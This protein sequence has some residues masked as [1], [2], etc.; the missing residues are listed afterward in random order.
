MSSHITDDAHQ[1]GHPNLMYMGMRRFLVILT[2]ALQMTMFGMLACAR[3]V[4]HE[5]EAQLD[6]NYID[7]EELEDKTELYS[8]LTKQDV[9]FAV[10]V[11]GVKVNRHLYRLPP[12][13]RVREGSPFQAPDT[14][15]LLGDVRRFSERQI[16][17]RP[18]SPVASMNMGWVE[19]E[20]RN[21]KEAHRW[22]S[23]SVARADAAENDIVKCTSRLEYA[24][25]LVWGRGIYTPEMRISQSEIQ[26]LYNAFRDGCQELEEWHMEQFARGEPAMENIVKGYLRRYPTAD[27][28]GKTP[29]IDPMEVFTGFRDVGRAATS[30]KCDGCGNQFFKVRACSG[31][32]KTSYCGKTCQV[33]HWK[34]GHKQECKILQS[35]KV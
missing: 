17:V 5:L 4:V 7:F 34:A 35:S 8:G 22:Y 19:I 30:Y 14:E 26:D 2:D 9:E 16:Q 3:Q 31:C 15:T 32:K 1:V 24:G 25:S 12:N 20:A 13:Q 27:R 28:D 23:E 11:L 6:G 29:A 10:A 21:L 18:D 33:K